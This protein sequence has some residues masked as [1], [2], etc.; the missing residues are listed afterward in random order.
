MS[1]DEAVSIF[2]I[3]MRGTGKTFVGERA[4]SALGWTFVDADRYLETEVRIGVRELVHQKAGGSLPRGGVADSEGASGGEVGPQSHIT[5]LGGGIVETTAAREVL[6]EC[7]ANE[8]PVVRVARPI[9]EIRRELAECWSHDFINPV[10][11]LTSGSLSSVQAFANRNEITHFFKHSTGGQPNFAHNVEPGRSCLPFLAYPDVQQ[12][13]PC[14][15]ELMEGVDA[16]ELRVDSLKSER[17]YQMIGD[18]IPSISTK[19]Q[20]QV[21]PDKA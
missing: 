1:R 18:S 10:G 21:F 9:D 2:L 19:P 6:R 16:M 5:N 3:G 8:D 20:G 17:D 14:I 7:A 4:T 15:Q 13:F 12:A 11:D